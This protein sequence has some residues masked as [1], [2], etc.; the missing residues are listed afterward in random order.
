MID[1]FYLPR[2]VLIFLLSTLGLIVFPH[3]FN[4]PVNLM[5]LFYLMLGWR[6]IGMWKPL[7]L[8]NKVLL[9]MLTTGGMALLYFQHQGVVGRDAGTSLFVTALGLKLL[10]IKSERDIY[11]INFLAFIVAASQFLFQQSIL[12]A[13]YILFVCCV[14]VATLFCVNSHDHKTFSALKYA[15]LLIL[16]GL[17]ISIVLFILFPRVEAPRWILFDE[18]RAKSGLSD[19]MEPGSI[20]DLVLSDDLVF[21]VRFAGELPPAWQRYWRGPVL[22]WTDGKRWTQAPNLSVIKSPPSPQFTGLPYQYTLLMEPQNKN[23]V[24]GLEMVA[25]YGFPVHQNANYQLVTS[26]DPNKRAEY[27]ITSYT[28]FNTGSLSAREA[29]DAL[30]LPG[31]ASYNI[32]QLVTNLQGFDGDPENFIKRVLNHFKVENFHYTLTPPLAEDHPIETF[33]FESR[34]GFC[35]HYASAFVYLMRIADIPARVVT[36]YQGGELNPVGNFLEIRQSDAHAWA[37]VWLQNKGWVRVDPTAAIAPERIENTINPDQLVAG[38]LIRYLSVDGHAQGAYNWLR[39]ARQLWGHV[40][41]NWQRWVINY[42][43][44]NQSRF[45]SKWGIS[46]LKTMIYGMVAAASLIIGLLAWML[47]HQKQKSTAMALRI[48]QRFCKKLAKQGLIISTGEGPKDFAAR[49]RFK[50]PAYAK[51]IDFISAGF[52]RLHYGKDP[53]LEELKMFRR[54]VARFKI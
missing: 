50:F 39:Q 25:D 46:D 15:S 21:R 38:E 41:Y 24:Y 37:E 2:P 26:D 54:R 17:P 33:L 4:L 36:G 5:V 44:K 43:N 13:A 6:F 9:F 32:K 16:Q 47:L 34:Q 28:R 35:S 18:H 3:F 7:W 1:K 14:L 45:L 20:S 40:D 8:P 29:Q 31:G 53:S 22:S 12:M 27:T 11:L 52:I 19:T 51:E 42:D 10:E 49:A 23:W 30:Q 48:Y